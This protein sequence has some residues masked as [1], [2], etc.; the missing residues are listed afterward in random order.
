VGA[1]NFAA[2]KKRDYRDAAG[3]VRLTLSQ[4]WPESRDLARRFD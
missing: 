4:G 3:K 1:I 2:E